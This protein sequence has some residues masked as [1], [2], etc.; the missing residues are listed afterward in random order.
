[1]N[2]TKQ[3]WV[4]PVGMAT[5]HLDRSMLVRQRQRLSCRSSGFKLLFIF[6]DVCWGETNAKRWR[7]FELTH[8]RLGRGLRKISICWL[9]RILVY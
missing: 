8:K 9:F 2:L 5:A 4:L 1:M 6:T 7:V 3:G